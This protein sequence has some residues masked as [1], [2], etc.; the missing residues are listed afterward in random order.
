M[1]FSPTKTVYK[2]N[3]P[4]G[5]TGA[6]QI[7]CVSAYP[8]GAQTIVVDSR[9][10]SE[11]STVTVSAPEAT[12]SRVYKISYNV[13]E[14]AYS[15]LQDLKVGGVTIPGFAPATLSYTYPLPLGTTSVPAVTWTSGD[16]YQT[17]TKED[18]GIDG[19]T[20][21]TV[22][23]PYPVFPDGMRNKHFYIQD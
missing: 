15:Y 17:I 22:K 9:D 10:I 20:K 23:A 21:I 12:S 6:Q 13:T 11:T 16:N 8:E 2:V 19:V 4:V 7:T 1:G 3:V 18:G 5:T 14:S